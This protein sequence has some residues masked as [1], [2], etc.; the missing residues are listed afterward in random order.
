MNSTVQA[1][2]AIPELQHALN[3]YDL[4]QLFKHGSNSLQSHY[5]RYRTWPTPAFDEGAIHFPWKNNG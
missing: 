4:S 1:L 2:R 3:T 5:R